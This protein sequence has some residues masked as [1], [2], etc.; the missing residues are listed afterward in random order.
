MESIVNTKF[1]N[2]INFEGNCNSVFTNTANIMIF[3]KNTVFQNGVSGA[4]CCQDGTRIYHRSSPM[5]IEYDNSTHFGVW[6]G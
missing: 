6:R 1:G 2:Y 4:D 5:L 3:R